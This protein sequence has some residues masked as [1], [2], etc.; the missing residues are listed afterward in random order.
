MQH[1]VHS[2]SAGKGPT[3]DTCGW[4][5]PGLPGEGILSRWTG[6]VQGPSTA[7]RPLCPG[8]WWGHALWLYGRQTKAWDWRGWAGGGLGLCCSGCGSDLPFDPPHF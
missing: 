5:V 1:P 3:L 4:A 7:G 2:R 8:S 6:W